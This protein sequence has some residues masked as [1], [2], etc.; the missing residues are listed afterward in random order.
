MSTGLDTG[1]EKL[2]GRFVCR[3][4]A[5]EGIWLVRIYPSYE[6]SL[7]GEMWTGHHTF[8]LKLRPQI[9]L[10]LGTA[11]VLGRVIYGGQWFRHFINQSKCCNIE[12]L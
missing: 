10:F 11:C 9:D 4:H 12:F 2:T 8:L 3:L 1:H 5:R 7:L 6:L